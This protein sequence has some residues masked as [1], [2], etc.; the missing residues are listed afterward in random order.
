M[1]VPKAVAWSPEDIEIMMKAQTAVPEADLE[2]L[3]QCCLEVLS[4]LGFWSMATPLFFLA[5]LLTKV[6]LT[7][8]NPM[9][10]VSAEDAVSESFGPFPEVIEGLHHLLSDR[11]GLIKC[12]FLHTV[13][14]AIVSLSELLW[15]PAMRDEA[16]ELHWTLLEAFRTFQS[17][18]CVIQCSSKE[19]G[20]IELPA[21]DR[22][23]SEKD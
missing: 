19:S 4:E 15:H 20:V 16:D 9:S 23:A 14:S 7:R 17:I 18:E 2:S 10:K 3:C 1:R 22:Q 13:R 21:P 6:Q 5:D 12:D 11:C 8:E